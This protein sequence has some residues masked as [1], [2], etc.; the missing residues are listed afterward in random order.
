ML[1]NNPRILSEAIQTIESGT[2]SVQKSCNCTWEHMQ[3][4]GASKD[5]SSLREFLRVY[6]RGW[7]GLSY[8]TC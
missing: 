5:V 4:E 1:C 7:T 3:V 6:Q 2:P 8:R